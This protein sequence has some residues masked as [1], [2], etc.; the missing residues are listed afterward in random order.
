MAR[1]MRFPVRL[2]S[3]GSGFWYEW[4]LVSEADNAPQECLASR[5]QYILFFSHVGR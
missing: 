1:S 2:K 3:T 5:R 4:C